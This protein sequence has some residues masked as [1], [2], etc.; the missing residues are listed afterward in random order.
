MK[1]YYI[2]KLPFLPYFFTIFHENSGFCQIL[3]VDFTKWKDN[4]M[5]KK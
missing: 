5:V 1:K 4:T 3:F 2:S